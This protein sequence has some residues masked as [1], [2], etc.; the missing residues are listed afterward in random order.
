MNTLNEKILKTKADEYV[1][2][3]FW[4]CSS[5]PRGCVMNGS[6]VPVALTDA[7]SGRTWDFTLEREGLQGFSARHRKS[8]FISNLPKSGSLEHTNV[9]FPDLGWMRWLRF[10]HLSRLRGVKI[11]QLILS[12]F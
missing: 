5:Q 10:V 3:C 11:L 2:T 6:G 4:G 8:G 1:D 9:Y 7:V 12:Q